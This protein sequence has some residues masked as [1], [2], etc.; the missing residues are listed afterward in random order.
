M[1]YFSR[2]L[3]RR[4]KRR[5]GLHLTPSANDPSPTAPQSTTRSSS[6]PCA[7]TSPFALSWDPLCAAAP[8]PIPSNPP[9][10]TSFLSVAPP[11][12]RPTPSAPLHSAVCLASLRSTPTMPP[13]ILSA[14][15]TN[16]ASSASNP[17]SA[18]SFPLPSA[19]PCLAPVAD[20]QPHCPASHPTPQ[21]PDPPAATTLVCPDPSSIPA[22]CSNDTP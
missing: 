21:A 11:S 6:F 8:I 22:N 16:P 4:F 5:L 2:S 1:V 3:V 19:V 9:C 13:E 15:S 7:G 20:A 18:G 17:N 14:P 12:V 10:V